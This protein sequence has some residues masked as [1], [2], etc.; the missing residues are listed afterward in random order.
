MIVASV[1]GELPTLHVPE[2]FSEKDGSFTPL[3]TFLAEFGIFK[4]KKKIST[5]PPN[6][7]LF[8]KNGIF[9][10]FNTFYILWE[11]LKK[12]GELPPQQW[13]N[14]D[15]N[16]GIFAI[17]RQIYVDMCWTEF[18][19]GF[20]FSDLEIRSQKPI[21]IR[22]LFSQG[23]HDFWGPR[24]YFLAIPDPGILGQSAANPIL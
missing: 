12:S 4:E 17:L 15:K 9:T 1:G 19:I 3:N 18:K 7:P 11:F 24:G 13:H 16:G 21:Q 2:H 8:H 5:F 22:V 6:L 23:K 14:W 10:T 20:L